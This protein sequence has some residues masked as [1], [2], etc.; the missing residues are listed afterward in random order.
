MGSSRWHKILL[1]ILLMAVTSTIVLYAIRVIRSP[2]FFWHLKTGQWIWE[3]RALPQKDPFSFAS[4]QAESSREHFILKAYWLSQLIFYGFYEAGGWPGIIVLR[5]IVVGWLLW[6]LAR[7]VKGDDIIR[8]SLL[9]IFLTVFLKDYFND[10]PQVFSFI[11]YAWLLFLLDRLRQSDAGSSR[12]AVSA[13]IPILMAAW[14]NMHGGHVIGQLTIV[15]YIVMEG[16]KFLHVKLGPTDRHTYRFIVSVGLIGLI[17]SFVNPN[18]YHALIELLRMPP[19]LFRVTEYLPTTEV[20]NTLK[21]RSMALY[22]LILLMTGCALVVTG[23]RNDITQATILA[24]TGYFSFTSMR[25]VPF[26][27][28]AA[29]PFLVDSLS[30]LR[31]IRWSRPAVAA[32]ALSGALYF[33][34]GE[35]GNISRAMSGRWLSGYTAPERAVTF[36]LRADLKGNMYNYYDYGGYLIWRLSPERKVFLDGRS[37]DPRVYE[38]SLLINSAGSASADELPYWKAAFAAYDINYVVVR[39]IESNDLVLP[40]CRAMLNDND[41]VPVFSDINT[42]IFVKAT[43]ENAAVINHFE[44]PRSAILQ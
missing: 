3:H 15:H 29:L 5:F 26:F 41:W 13:G 35:T 33:S 39:R 7:Y 43:P 11:F 40:L 20:F 6:L 31:I 19:S 12:P 1:V 9:L 21:I 38:E 28:I 32:L 44:I 36:I 23:N 17:C 16:M 25:Y 8:A 30:D 37:I 10:R 4:P 22:W 34:A 24:A 2:D 18:T 27:M 42:L 14:A